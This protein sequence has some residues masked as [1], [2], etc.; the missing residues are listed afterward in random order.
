MITT[1]DDIII[2]FLFHFVLYSETN[3]KKDL[4]RLN[5]HSMKSYVYQEIVTGAL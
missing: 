4:V 3:K 5:I 2:S 1:K